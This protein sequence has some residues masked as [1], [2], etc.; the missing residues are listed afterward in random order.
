VQH[1]LSKQPTPGFGCL[2]IANL[3]LG[4]NKNAKTEIADYFGDWPEGMGICVNKS[5]NSDKKK[6]FSFASD[7]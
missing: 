3:P 6:R 4:D 5:E 1:P 2:R 7:L